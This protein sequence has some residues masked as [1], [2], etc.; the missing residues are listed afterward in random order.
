MDRLAG[1]IA[2]ISGGSRGIGA[3]IAERFLSEGA[4]VVIGDVLDEDGRQ[5]A[6]RLGDG[7]RY[8]HLDVTKPADWERAVK[9]TVDVFG[10]LGILVNNAGIVNFGRI[11]DYSHEQWARIINVNLTG[12]FNGIKAA[13]TSLADAG[14]AS[15]INISSIAG[16]RGYEQLSGYTASKFGVRGLTKSAALDLGGSGIRVNSVHPGVIETPM[17]AGMVF[18]TD[19]VPL[20]RIGQPMEI[21]DLVLYLAGDESAF[22]TGAEFVIDGGETAGTVA[23]R[24]P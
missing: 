17:T 14:A 13:A 19:R 9:E 15:I 20:R 23:P 2:L 24:A 7:V 6:A 21:A 22:V 11:D 8:V 12:V 4:K 1:K 5:L 10:G 16:L 18:E 3:A